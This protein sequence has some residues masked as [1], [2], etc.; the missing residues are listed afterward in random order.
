MLFLTDQ[1]FGWNHNYFLVFSISSIL[2]CQ[3]KDQ[4]II[5]NQILTLYIS[6]TCANMLII[7]NDENLNLKDSS[8]R[9]IYIPSKVR[10]N[11]DTEWLLIF[12]LEPLFQVHIEFYNIKGN[13]NKT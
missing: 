13:L 3:I 6:L 8:D 12:S 1:E 4:N 11:S 10:N 9:H 7:R 5:E 2:T